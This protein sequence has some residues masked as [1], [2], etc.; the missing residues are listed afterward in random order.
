M[1]TLFSQPIHHTAGNIVL[2][3]LVFRLFLCSKHCWYKPFV[4]HP[5][6]LAKPHYFSITLGGFFFIHLKYFCYNTNHYFCSNIHSSWKSKN[7]QKH[8][9]LSLPVYF[10]FSDCMLNHWNSNNLWVKSWEQVR[11]YRLKGLEDWKR[12]IKFLLNFLN[13]LL[14]WTSVISQTSVQYTNRYKQPLVWEKTTSKVI[15]TVLCNP[16]ETYF[17]P[18]NKWLLV[19]SL[20]ATKTNWRETFNQEHKE[21]CWSVFKPLKSFNIDSS[22]EWKSRIWLIYWWKWNG[23]ERGFLWNA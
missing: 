11:K 12:Q 7:R 4:L 8:A 6:I 20:T 13:K 15:S 17:F 23:W 1:N 2:Q 14:Y 5:R 22:I 16:I 21:N 18:E 10:R 3:H 19:S 9:W